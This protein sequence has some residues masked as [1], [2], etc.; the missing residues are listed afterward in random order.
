M[1]EE[2]H[3][4]ERSRGLT[5][6]PPPPILSSIASASF[7]HSRASRAP[8]PRRGGEVGDQTVEVVAVQ[9][10]AAAVRPRRRRCKWQGPLRP[11]AAPRCQLIQATRASAASTFLPERERSQGRVVDGGLVA[12]EGQ[13]RRTDYKH[14]QTDG[15]MRGIRR[16]DARVRETLS[17]PTRSKLICC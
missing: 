12:A 14:S 4:R 3:D 8:S 13:A 9:S 11:S 16:I 2:A 15:P 6:S 10:S 17:S 5:R 1:E 7:P